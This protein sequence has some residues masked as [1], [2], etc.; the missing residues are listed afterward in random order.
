MEA[1]QTVNISSS[2]IDEL[3]EAIRLSLSEG[4]TESVP[5][6][7]HVNLATVGQ[8]DSSAL[9]AALLIGIVLAGCCVGVGVSRW[10]L[11]R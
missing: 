7:M 6:T 8:I 2:S 4:T 10:M 1:T 9:A 3:A 5:A 11:R